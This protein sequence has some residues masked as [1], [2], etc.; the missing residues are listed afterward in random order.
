MGGNGRRLFSPLVDRE[1]PHPVAELW[2]SARERAM[3]EDR[4]PVVIVPSRDWGRLLIVHERDLPA[5]AERSA[6]LQPPA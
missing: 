4:L 5:L 3:A 2:S 6:E 1:R